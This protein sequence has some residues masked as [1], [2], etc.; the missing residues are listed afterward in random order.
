[1]GNKNEFTVVRGLNRQAMRGSKKQSPDGPLA[2]VMRGAENF[3]KA[4]YLYKHIPSTK[5]TGLKFCETI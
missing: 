4:K 5:L 1:M 2:E 3:S